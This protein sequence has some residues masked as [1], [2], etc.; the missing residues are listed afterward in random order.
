MA[1]AILMISSRNY[2]SWSLRGWL[3]TR[4]AGL[5]V[6][7]RITSLDD[8]AA[9]AEITMNASSILLPCLIHEGVTIWDVIAIAEY[10]NERFPEAKMLPDD[11]VARGHCRSISGEM[12]AG[13]A[14]LR[15]ALPMNLKRRHAG[16]RVWA[17]AQADI[18][19]ICGLWQECLD[20]SGGPYLFG[21]RLTI[22]DAMY[23]PV[24]TRFATYGVE[25][26]GAANAYYRTIRAWP[27]LMRWTAL[28]QH[29]PE[30]VTELELEF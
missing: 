8:P 21:K 6:E 12:H 15:A 9:R 16:F 28:A 18:D 20:R 11:P 1:D 3:L 4:L 5:D 24:V 19:R 2:S 29:E 17:G 26:K 23:A 30:E 25:T 22:A 27:D 10:L 7:E 14:T 13:F